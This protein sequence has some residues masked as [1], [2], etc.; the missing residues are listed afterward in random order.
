MALLSTDQKLLKQEVL[1]DIHKLP[2][3]AC[4]P[5]GAPQLLKML[6]IAWASVWSDVH[7]QLQVLVRTVEENFLSL[8]RGKGIQQ[9]S[10]VPEKK[11]TI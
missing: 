4:V 11:N 7:R 6:T 1:H 5:F 8:P 3:H 10:G 9:H 2:T